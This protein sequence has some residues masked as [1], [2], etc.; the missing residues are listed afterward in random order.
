M[1][2]TSQVSEYELAVILEINALLDKI[3]VS[4][5]SHEYQQIAKLVREYLSHHCDHVIVHDN[6]DITPDRSE[7]ICYCSRCFETFRTLP[8]QNQNTTNN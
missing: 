6:I 4:Y 3:P 2:E 7:R 1:S 5:H 8:I